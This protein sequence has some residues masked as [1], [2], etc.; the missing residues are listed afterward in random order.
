MSRKLLFTSIVLGFVS[1]V[2]AKNVVDCRVVTGNTTECS[3]YASKF[4]H[5][6]E[7]KY[8]EDRKKLIISKT[9]PAPQKLNMRVIPIDEMIE[10][11]VKVEDSLRFKR[12]HEETPK[13][14]KLESQELSED[15][16]QVAVVPEV[17]VEEQEALTEQRVAEV[18]QIISSEEAEEKSIAE[19]EIAQTKVVEEKVEFGTYKVVSG[20]VL[21]R[22]ANKFELSIKELTALN[23]ID[24]KKPLR[25]GQILKIPMTQK[26]VD[27]ISTGKYT[28]EP[29]DTLLT[30]AKK[31]NV[32]SKE[33][34]KFNNIKTN[35]T[36][37][38]GKKLDLPLPYI[39]KR[40]EAE[41][42]RLAEKKR[43]E[44]IKRA[45]R[46]AKKKKL[47][48]MRGMKRKL[49]V[50][51]TAYTSHHGQTDSTPFLAA[52]NNRLRPG[53]KI[54]AVSRDMLTRY[55]MR[56]GTKV[57]I[58]GLSGYYTVRDKMN[59]RYRKRIDIY[60]GL[61]RRRALRWGRRSVVI[62]W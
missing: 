38:V 17:K 40:V 49:R 51:A 28:I 14:E 1:F 3:Q 5:A 58:G 4:I 33:L 46:L 25:L 52:W 6:K 41:K 61:D 19:A 13:Q 53:M 55:G 42:K 62:Y 59:K 30:I 56:N 37:R 27:A 11:Y 43:Q 60:M 57:R 20:D 35:A 50:T 29:N 8:A 21:G 26:R 48:I 15:V 47:K 9:L 39:V 23:N 16:T 12:T 22:I 34:A 31:F 24:K 32:T 45:K 44:A 10:N 7:I 18:E 2:E 54:I 36:I